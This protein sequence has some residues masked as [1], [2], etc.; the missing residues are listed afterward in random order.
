MRKPDPVEVI[1]ITVPLLAELV[2]V[3]FAI[4]VA[5]LW[6]GILSGAI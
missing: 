5:I 6:A 1:A 2:V 4:G 3:S